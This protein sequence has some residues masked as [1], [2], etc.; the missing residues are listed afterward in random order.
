M[1]TKRC[2]RCEETKSVSEFWKD[3]RTKSGFQG[4]CK[5]C[6]RGSNT[7][8]KRVA[9]PKK[10]A[11]PKFC[12]ICG[13]LKNPDDFYFN[14]S[15]T[16]GR[17]PYCKPC[18][19]IYNKAHPAGPDAKYRSDESARAAGLRRFGL[20]IDEF[21]AMLAD[22]G[23]KCAIC[24]TESCTTG[25]RFSV[26]HDKITGKIRG[27]LCRRC[28]QGIGWFDHDPQILTSAATYLLK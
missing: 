25:R 11:K 28:N 7:Y 18:A 16:D 2:P 26:D 27:L 12:G 24:R 5:A 8:Q 19:R 3:R 4:Y 22:Q 23:G 17:H 20:S 10:E 21:E 9:R 1:E 15:S 14:R 13:E 6:Q